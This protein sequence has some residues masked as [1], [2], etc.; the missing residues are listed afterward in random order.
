MEI[1]VIMVHSFDIADHQGD[2][3]T[4]DGGSLVGGDGGEELGEGEADHFPLSHAS[5]RHHIR[6]IRRR[7]LANPSEARINRAT[8]TIETKTAI[9]KATNSSAN[10]MNNGPF[11]SNAYHPP[12]HDLPPQPHEHDGQDDERGEGQRH[13]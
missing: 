4:L 2:V 11:L 10:P 6:P 9:D 1:A 12:P 3:C 13:G 5:S 7:A 8:V